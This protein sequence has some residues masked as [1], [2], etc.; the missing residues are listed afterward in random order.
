MSNATSYSAVLVTGGAVRVGRAIALTLAE[1]GMAVAVH[2]RGS[3]EEAKS[4]VGE[5][6]KNGGIAC[7][8]QADL[9]DAQ[10]TA[11]LI[12]AASKSLDQPIDVLINNASVFENDT[13]AT[14]S[15]DSW[16]LHQA[17][18]LRAP[19][20]LTQQMAKALPSSRKGCV[21]NIVDQRVL[22]LNPQ[23]FSYTASKAGLWT[24]TRT[25]AQSLAP[26][27]RVNAIGPGPTLGNQFQDAA[28]FEQESKSVMLGAGPEL[29]EIPSA[30]Q[31]LLETPSITG[32]MI[33]LDGG[34][35]LAWRTPDILEE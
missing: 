4:L 25:M 3:S 8:V 34:Q 23:Y 22:K 13:L 17:V 16:D 27:I 6:E 24:V 31:F 33:T 35:H 29:S 30:V 2:H 28:D 11:G 14:H 19:V 15:V 5:I 9:S 26:M 32:Q 18:N 21:I 10:Q 12:A 7:T 1:Q 20:Q